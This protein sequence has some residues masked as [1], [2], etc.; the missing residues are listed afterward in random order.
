MA[1][2]EWERDEKKRCRGQRKVSGMRW[3]WGRE[4]LINGREWR[5]LKRKGRKEREIVCV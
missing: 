1:N 2:L 4:R 3:A 5:K